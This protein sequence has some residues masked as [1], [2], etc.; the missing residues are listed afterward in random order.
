MTLLGKILV[1]VNLV[2]SLAMASFALA[3]YTQR[4]NWTNAPPQTTPDQAA[5]ELALLQDEIKRKWVA[6]THA[7]DGSEKRLQVL[8]DRLRQREQLRPALQRW[9]AQEIKHAARKATDKDPVRALVFEEGK[10]PADP[11]NPTRPKLQPA[12]DRFGNNLASLDYYNKETKR[13]YDEINTERENLGKLIAE[14]KKQT[15]RAIELR[16]LIEDEEDKRKSVERELRDFLRP[17]LVN[18]EVESELILRRRDAL[19]ER[20]EELKKAPARQ[21]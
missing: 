9:Y 13:V 11:A 8:T 14:D 16:Q 1:C 6:L 3:L 17:T 2:F 10:I 20:V 15:E 21:P 5:G 12:K 7:D 4:I 18:V 19:Q